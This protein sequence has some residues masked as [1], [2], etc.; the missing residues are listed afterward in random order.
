MSRPPMLTLLLVAAL[1]AP[2]TVARAQFR[3]ISYHAHPNFN[4]SDALFTQ[5][6]DF[7]RD[8]GYHTV[9]G[10]QFMGWLQNNDPLPIRPLFRSAG[11]A[12]RIP[13]RG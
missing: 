11:R 13:S 5:H 10:D 3:V 9:S 7:L 12:K 4:Y 8:N 6:M 2:T 1:F